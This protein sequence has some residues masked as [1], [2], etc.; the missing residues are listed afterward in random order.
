[1]TDHLDL[2]RIPASF[3][4]PPERLDSPFK[5][6]RQ[7]GVGAS[8]RIKD[9]TKQFG[10]V[11]AVKGVTLDTSP[12]EFITLLGPS[13]S[14]KTTT[15]MMVAG[16]HLPSSGEIFIADR[17]VTYLQPHRRNVGVVFQNYALFP[18]MT[19]AENIAFPLRMRHLGEAEIREKVESALELVRLPG[20]GSRFPS[21]LSGGQQQRVALARAIVFNPDVLLMDEPL[22]ALDRKLRE[23]MQV[24][25]K[26]LHEALRITVIYVTHDQTEALAMSDRVAVMNNGKIEQVGRPKELYEQPANSFVADFLGESNFMSGWVREV[27]GDTC[28]VTTRG[29]I[30]CVA[31]RSPQVGIGTKVNLLVRPERV[32]LLEEAVSVPNQYEGRLDQITYTGDIIKYRISLSAHEVVTATVQNRAQG[33]TLERGETV[34]VGWRAEDVRIFPT[35]TGA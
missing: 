7:R 30:D 2:Q 19:V 32:L 29:Q 21:Q 17:P 34:K 33:K 1:M 28:S 15:I 14:G 11:W 9:L 3:E 25:I 35:S 8:V 4:D 22:G 24:E 18:H 5:S 23:H 12:G 31:T 10:E 13:G 16:F 26:A 27:E 20:Y 6:G